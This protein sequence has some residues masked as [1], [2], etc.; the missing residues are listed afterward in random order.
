MRCAKS[1]IGHDC[2]QFHD[3][4]D[5]VVEGCILCNKKLIYKKINGKIDEAEYYRDHLRDFCQPGTR[6][7]DKVYGK[8]GRERVRLWNSRRAWTPKEQAQH[9]DDAGREAKEY[10]KSLDDNG[11][12]RINR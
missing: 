4:K 6:L 1:E 5:A 9:W 2:I 8:K 11:K 3:Y 12:E 10:M 7:F